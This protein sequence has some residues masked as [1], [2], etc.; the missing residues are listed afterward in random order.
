MDG[1]RGLLKPAGIIRICVFLFVSG[2]R[3]VNGYTSM[4]LRRAGQFFF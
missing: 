2:Y 4:G 1:I 3:R